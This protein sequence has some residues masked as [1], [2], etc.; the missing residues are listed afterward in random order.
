MKE[1]SGREVSNEKGIE[2]TTATDYASREA[3]LL[4][5]V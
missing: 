1:T 2:G 5:Y 3:Q 4:G